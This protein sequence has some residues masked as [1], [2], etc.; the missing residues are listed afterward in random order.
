[1]YTLHESLR[2]VL[3]I[4]V[5]EVTIVPVV[6]GF[7]HMPRENDGEHN[8]MYAARAFSGFFVLCSID[9]FLDLAVTYLEL[10]WASE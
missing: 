3:M 2:T 1:M 9:E 10:N 7:A 8:R 5:T 6:A 4:L